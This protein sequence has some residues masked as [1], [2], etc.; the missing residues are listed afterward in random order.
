MSLNVNEIEAHEFAT[1]KRGYDPDQVRSYLREVA[2]SLKD[3]PGRG[4]GVGR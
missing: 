1:V 2:T 4:Y 3:A